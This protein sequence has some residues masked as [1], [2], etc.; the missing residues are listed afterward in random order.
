MAVGYSPGVLE[1][2]TAAMLHLKEFPL[3]RDAKGRIPVAHQVHGRFRCPFFK[4][5][6]RYIAMTTS[7]ALQFA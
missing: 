5:P 4:L 3:W 1:W 2:Y 7:A 6:H